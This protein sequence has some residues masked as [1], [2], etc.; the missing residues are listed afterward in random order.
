MEIIKSIIML[1]V[2]ALVQALPEMLK[3]K[4]RVV[5]A[6]ASDEETR[7]RVGRAFSEFEGVDFD[8]LESAS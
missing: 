2:N 4:A 5:E 6:D 7:E 1:F 3:D 8:A